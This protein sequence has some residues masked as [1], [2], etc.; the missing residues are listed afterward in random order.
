M[1]KITKQA[2]FIADSLQSLDIKASY[3][4]MVKLTKCLEALGSIASEAQKLERENE[5]FK[6][7]LGLDAEPNE[8]SE[9]KIEPVSMDEMP[10][11]ATLI[12]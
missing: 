4:L 10:E 8:D 9:I 5:E 11:D 1:S 3:E 12:E 2:Q 7:A 6:K